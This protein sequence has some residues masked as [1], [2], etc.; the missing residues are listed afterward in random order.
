MVKE[1]RKMEGRGGYDWSNAEDLTG[2]KL[3]LVG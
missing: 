2:S 3:D 1:A